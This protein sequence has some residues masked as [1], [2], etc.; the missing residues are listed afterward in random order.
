MEPLK[1]VF[2]G[3][4]RHAFT[5]SG[6]TRH[7]RHTTK[8]ACSAIYQAHRESLP[9]SE[10]AASDDNMESGHT[11]F[12]DD[13][14][15]NDY[16]PEDFGM[17]EQDGPDLDLAAEDDYDAGEFEMHDP[18]DHD[19]GLV[20]QHGDADAN[21]AQNSDNDDYEDDEEEAAE[22]AELEVSWEAEVVSPSHVQDRSPSP[23]PSHSPSPSISSFD[24]PNIPALLGPGLENFLGS[25]NVRVEQF[26]ILT[27][28]APVSDFGKDHGYRQYKSNLGNPQTT[29]APFN[30]KLDWEFASW[31]KLRG[32]SS[33]A[34]QE[35]LSIDGV[36]LFQYYLLYKFLLCVV[37]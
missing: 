5:L 21:L 20:A 13:V 9:Y 24:L 34:L 1:H 26:P 16:E 14:F 12:G 35:L 36:G 29:F 30:S 3:G 19:L 4:C 18:V 28:G 32:P 7:L 33:S 25:D 10:E 6:L 23:S 27:A 2:C 11:H 17:D 15:G 37:L 31:A 8:A 22:M